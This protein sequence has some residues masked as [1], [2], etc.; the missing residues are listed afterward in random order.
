MTREGKSLHGRAGHVTFAARSLELADVRLE[1]AGGVLA[2]SGRYRPGLV[3]IDAR[4]EALDLGTLGYV[5]GF[6]A[7]H[8]S[9][10]VSVNAE[11]ALASDVRRGTL[12]ATVRDG[13]AGPLSGVTLDLAT[14]LE[15]KNLTGNGL[16]ELRGVGRVRSSFD[17]RVEGSLLD[18]RAW[19]RATGR[20]DLGIE[21][22]ALPRVLPFLP[23]EW[24]LSKLEGA[25]VAQATLARE[26]A[27]EPPSVTLLAATDGLLI[28]HA[29]A[30]GG[31]P[32]VIRGIEAQLSANVDGKHDFA[33]ADLRLIDGHGLLSSASG[34]IAVDMKRALVAPRDVWGL[35]RVSP[36]VATLIM[37][38]RPLDELP[39]PI[40]PSGIFGTLRAELGLRGTFA[41]P[42]LTAKGS[43]EHL[44][45]SDSLEV[46]PFDACGALQYDPTTERLGVGLQAHLANESG[47]ACSGARVAVGSAVGTIDR[48]RLLRGERGFR[49]E[50]QLSFEDFPLELVPACAEAGMLGRVR[51]VAALTDGGEL[52]ALN[53]R[54]RLSDVT[55][56]K[57]PVGTGDLMLRSDV[58]AVTVGVKLERAGGTL[59]AA[60]HAAVGW[61]RAVPALDREQ[62]LG[63]S[64][65]IHDIDAAIL[66]PLVGDVL[67]DLSGRLDGAVALTLAAPAQKPGANGRVSELSGKLSLRDGALQL[68]GLGMR[69]SQVAFVAEARRVD[70]RTVISVRD[71]SAASGAKYRNVSGS[72]DLY[73]NGLSLT[74]ARANVNLR[75]VPLLIEGVSQATLTGSAALELFPDKRPILVAIQ[76]HDLTA[77]LPHTS[78]RA[79]LSVDENPDITV[80]QPL[81]EPVRATKGGALAWELAFDLARKVRLTRADMEIP[82]R[83]RQV[84]SGR[85]DSLS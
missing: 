56:R 55:V 5:L 78:G 64:A 69:L 52:P 24:G 9:G 30:A 73:L 60:A 31:E 59:D 15:D 41:E 27:E 29:G 11:L 38:G 46:V 1:G 37:D 53:A 82:L 45:M 25:L 43:V 50:A 75:E 48:A 68:S 77:A 12:S 54:L 21:Q 61:D 8:L 28:E 85:S 33:Q 2:G 4:G 63:V 67:A 14:T 23:A 42:Y 26:D 13:S 20:W 47:G 49:G 84:W 71:I 18:A 83:G 72:A 7:Q 35:L 80:K 44:A 17:T 76:L 74:D 51:G 40:R 10:K 65:Q 34:R 57:I 36:V 32:L 6:G 62:P 39:E 79:V 70:S 66:S 16:L 3:E 81:R 58:R 19:R 22:L